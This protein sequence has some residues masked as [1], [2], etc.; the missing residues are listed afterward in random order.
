MLNNKQPLIIPFK[1]NQISK[2]ILRATIAP[3]LFGTGVVV[4][5]FFMQFLMKSL[6]KIIGKGLDNE[7]IFLLII[8]NLA[9]MVILAVPLGVLFASLLSFGTLSSYSEITVIK[10]SGGSLYRMMLPVFIAAVIVSYLLFLY[11]SEVVPET[12]HQ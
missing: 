3:F 5:L 6:D 1:M 7:V 8:Y 11:N 4:F 2:Y 12:N 10:A 9:W